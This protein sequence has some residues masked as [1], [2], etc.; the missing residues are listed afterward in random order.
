MRP[1]ARAARLFS[2]ASPSPPSRRS[3]APQA[4][5]FAA[6]LAASGASLLYMRMR[7]SAVAH[8]R[9]ETQQELFRTLSDH[10]PVLVS[11]TRSAAGASARP[12]ED[13]FAAFFRTDLMANLS[14]EA[15]GM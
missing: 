14:H 2:T 13:P 9:K 5:A 3:L 10:K 12:Q 7:D 6:L 15:G 8:W 1:L 11:L 4:A